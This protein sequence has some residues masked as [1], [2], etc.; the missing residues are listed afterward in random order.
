MLF[1]EGQS[2]DMDETRVKSKKRGAD[3]GEVCTAPREVFIP[4]ARGN[5]AEDWTDDKRYKK[6]GLIQDEITFIES[7]IRLM[8]EEGGKV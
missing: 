6:Y 1:E 7:M 5:I 3:Y 2:D 4:K 8:E